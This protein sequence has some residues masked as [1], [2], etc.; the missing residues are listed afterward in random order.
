MDDGISGGAEAKWPVFRHTTGAS[1]AQAEA[2]LDARE[3]PGR[4]AGHAPDTR[5]TRAVDN[6]QTPGGA[7]SLRRDSQCEPG[8][9]ST[10]ERQ[11]SWAWPTLGS[12]SATVGTPPCQGGAVSASLM[13]PWAVCG[14]LAFCVRS[15]SAGGSLRSNSWPRLSL[16]RRCDLSR[17]WLRA[18]VSCLTT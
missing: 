13:Q 4:L 6:F 10:G 17:D 2:M 8:L 11:L 18:F 5:R 3:T 14:P 12:G 9:L 7:F 15:G 1:V 16:L